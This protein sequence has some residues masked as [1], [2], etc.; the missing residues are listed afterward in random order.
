L[1]LTIA[2]LDLL[3]QLGNASSAQVIDDLLL[4]FDF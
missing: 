1:V 2:L 4:L 3:L